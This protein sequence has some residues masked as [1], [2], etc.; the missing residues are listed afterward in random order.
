MLFI[1]YLIAYIVWTI[2]GNI[3]PTEIRLIGGRNNL[4]GIYCH[5]LYICNTDRM[6]INSILAFLPLRLY[7]GTLSLFRAI[8]FGSLTWPVIQYLVSRI[9]SCTIHKICSIYQMLNSAAATIW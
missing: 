2:I 6:V 1:L 4:E 3:A 8:L 5:C 9:A 7:L